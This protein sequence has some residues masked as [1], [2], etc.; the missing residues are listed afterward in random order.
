MKFHK[1][2][3]TVEH[4]M[5][6]CGGASHLLNDGGHMTENGGVQQS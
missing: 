5:V 3:D 1:F 2:S 6:L 4:I